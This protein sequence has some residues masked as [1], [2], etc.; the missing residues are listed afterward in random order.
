[1]IV[2]SIA[3]ITDAFDG[4]VA[5][6][7]NLTTKL[8]IFLDPLADKFLVISA[9]LSFWLMPEMSGKVQFW[10]L[11]LIGFRDIIVTILRMVMQ[12]K[13]ITMITSKAG[14]WKTGFQIGAIEFILLYFIFIDFDFELVT[15]FY[16]D[17]HLIKSIMIFT[18]L[19]TFYTGVHY[20]VYNS[21]ILRE[22][23][24]K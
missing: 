11:I 14:K 8:G 17:Y 4:K 15:N 2:F 3:A 12:S 10:M 24:T 1:L 18:T 20:F 22:M 6:K 19:L 5:R 23:F 7:Y 21:K 13:G 16:N 9:F